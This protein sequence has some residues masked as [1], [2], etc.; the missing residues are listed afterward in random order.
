MG[1]RRRSLIHSW[2]LWI[3]FESWYDVQYRTAQDVSSESANA[4]SPIRQDHLD[5]Q[6]TPRDRPKLSLGRTDADEVG[7]LLGCESSMLTTKR[8][9]CAVDR[10]DIAFRELFK[11]DEV[12]GAGKRGSAGM[13]QCER[14]EQRSSPTSTGEQ[15]MMI[16]EKIIVGSAE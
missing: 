13:C 4:D 11:V 15:L 12:E 5:P 16:P 14:V 3:R 10:V 9:Y 2:T 1:T 7:D 6:L 8:L